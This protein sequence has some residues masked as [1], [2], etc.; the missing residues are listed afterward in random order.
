MTAFKSTPWHVPVHAST[1][2][3][4][5]AARLLQTRSPAGQSEVGRGTA[6]FGTPGYKCLQFFFNS[7]V[8]S[9]FLIPAQRL[10]QYGLRLVTGVR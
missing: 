5:N 4:L 6:F 9:R 3:S 2:N 8:N 10:L 7:R 1:I